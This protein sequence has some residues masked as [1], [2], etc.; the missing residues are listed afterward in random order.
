MNN[1][2][3]ITLAAFF[4]SSIATTAVATEVGGTYVTA[5][6]WSAEA[7]FGNGLSGSGVTI[8]NKDNVGTFVVG[9]KATDNL[10]IE[11]GVI[12]GGDVSVSY[13]GSGSGTYLGKAYSYSVDGS[14][15]AETDTSYTLGVNYSAPVSD[16][17]DVYGKAGLLFWD[18][19]YSVTGSGTFTYD[20]TGYTLAGSSKF[21]EADGNDAYVGIGA[22]YAIGQNSKLN[23]EYIKTEINGS[24][25][26]GLSASVAY[27][28]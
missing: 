5:G 26:D 12:S 9:Y 19:E 22:S 15:K 25:V 20:G 21:T 11:A 28:F 14:V 13:T 4:A 1:K 2:I 27:D 23:A 10:A 16:K 6:M 7:D 24:D 8:D 18:V 17:V 3:K